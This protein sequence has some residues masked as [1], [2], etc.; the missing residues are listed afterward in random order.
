MEQTARDML[1]TIQAM[2]QTSDY[3]G[4]QHSHTTLESGVFCCY[5]L[6]LMFVCFLKGVCEKARP[7]LEQAKEGM[8]RL[9]AIVPESAYYK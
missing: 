2:H 5:G 3:Q 7:Y 4:N 8:K 9:Q 1:A 6:K